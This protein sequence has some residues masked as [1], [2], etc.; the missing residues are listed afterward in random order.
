MEASGQMNALLMAATMILIG[1]VIVG[2]APAAAQQTDPAAGATVLNPLSQLDALSFKSFLQRPLFSADRRP[3][4][5][6]V[7]PSAPTQPEEEDPLSNLRLLG[8]TTGPAGAVARITDDKQSYSLNRGTEFRGW[9]VANIG[10]SSVTLSNQGDMRTFTVFAK[11]ISPSLSK[12]E[13][14]K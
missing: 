11:T 8:V 13:A 9:T 5:A 6:P 14:G 7:L 12:P 2:S 10:A 3:P 1:G 4:D